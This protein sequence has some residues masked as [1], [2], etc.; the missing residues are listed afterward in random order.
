MSLPKSQYVVLNRSVR[1]KIKKYPSNVHVFWSTSNKKIATVN[2]KGV[3]KG[4]SKAIAKITAKFKYAGRTYKSVCTVRVAPVKKYN[5]GTYK[6]G[7]DMPAGEY[8]LYST[9]RLAYFSI[10]SD[11]SGSVY[12]II[13]SAKRCKS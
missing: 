13:S 12:S 7:R 3:V 10:N 4:K 11:S 2:S 5:V 1:L 6:V 8:V 9:N